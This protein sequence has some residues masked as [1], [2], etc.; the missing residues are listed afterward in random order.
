MWCKLKSEIQDG[1]SQTWVFL[2]AETPSWISAFRWH[3]T[4]IGNIIEFLNSE[5][6]SVAGG[7][8]Q[9]CYI[10]AEI[11]VFPC[12]NSWCIQQS[13]L[14]IPTCAILNFWL[15]LAPHNI[16]NSFIEFLDQEN[17]GRAVGISQ[18]SCIQSELLLFYGFSKNNR[19][20]QPPSWI[21]EG[22]YR[23]HNCATL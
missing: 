3:H 20:I 4:V 17:M 15:P 1:G 9:L 18:L 5:N 23:W 7:I 11:L 22:Q 19:H 8:L 12:W 10:H 21:S 14:R 6:I 2:V 13:S 16:V